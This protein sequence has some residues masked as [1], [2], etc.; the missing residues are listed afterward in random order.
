MNGFPFTYSKGSQIFL[1]KE[2][3]TIKSIVHS[4]KKQYSKLK[5]HSLASKNKEFQFVD[6]NQVQTVGCD[7]ASPIHIIFVTTVNEM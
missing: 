1:T 3:H 4:T 2:P 5:K 6:L 7:S